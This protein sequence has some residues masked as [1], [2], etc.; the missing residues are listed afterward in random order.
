MLVEL[1]RPILGLMTAAS[2]CIVGGCDGGSPPSVETSKTETTVKGTVKINGEPATEGEVL[3]D[4]TNYQRKD[5]SSR[6]APIGKD[7]SFSISTYTG[8]NQV[9]LAGSIAKKHHIASRVAKEVNVKPGETVSLEFTE[10][11]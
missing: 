8:I 2:L 6:T 10:S 1:R 9:K 4:P 11:K 7:G 3:F 5:V